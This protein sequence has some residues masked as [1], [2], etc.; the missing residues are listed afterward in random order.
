MERVYEL[1]GETLDIVVIQRSDDWSEG[2]LRL[3]E[4]VLADLGSCHRRG[5]VVPGF[6]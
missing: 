2:G 1:L 3:L 6:T 4:K 5:G